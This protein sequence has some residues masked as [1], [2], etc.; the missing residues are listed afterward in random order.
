M[1]N[2]PSAKEQKKVSKFYKESDNK[3]YNKKLEFA[4]SD[5]IH[6]P[7]PHYGGNVTAN[8]LDNVQPQAGGNIT[9]GYKGK[10]VVGNLTA[11]EKGYWASEMCPVNVHWHLGSEHYSAGEYDENSSSPHGG[12]ELDDWAKSKLEE[13]VRA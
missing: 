3:C 12:R 11:R 8:A 13:D 5:C 2:I 1:N 6:V 4:N 7:G 10:M 9:A